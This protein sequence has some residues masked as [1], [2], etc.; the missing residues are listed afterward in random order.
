MSHF[1]KTL[2]SVCLFLCPYVWNLLTICYEFVYGVG[3]LFEYLR[4]IQFD[5][6][7]IPIQFKTSMFYFKNLKPDWILND[8]VGNL[9]IELC[10]NSPAQP[11][12]SATLSIQISRHFSYLYS[13]A[14][15]CIYVVLLL[16]CCGFASPLTNIFFSG[17]SVLCCPLVLKSHI[18]SNVNRSCWIS[19]LY[20]I[21]TSISNLSHLIT[22]IQN[23]S[24]WIKVFYGIITSISNLSHLITS[25]QS[26]LHL[27][28]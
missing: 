28:E 4:A 5:S 24:C 19:V 23:S 12:K 25:I 27:V 10:M 21:I 3:F 15:L 13:C 1:L 2:I 26:L 20:G 9:I 22:L 16:W 14:L 17:C 18:T 11:R 8:P 6:I 7:L